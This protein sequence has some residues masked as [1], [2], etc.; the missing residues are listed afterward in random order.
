M[1]PTAFLKNDFRGLMALR[2]NKVFI[3]FLMLYDIYLTVL[4]LLLQ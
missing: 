2:A 3:V 4:I 1:Q